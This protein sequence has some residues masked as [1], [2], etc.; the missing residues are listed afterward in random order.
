M[1]RFKHP[2]CCRGRAS[3]PKLLLHAIVSCL[4]CTTLNAGARAQDCLEWQYPGAD[5]WGRNGHAMTY[6]STHG[7]TVLFGGRYYE[8]DGLDGN[9]YSGETWTWDGRRWTL[10]SISGPPR[11]AAGSMAHDPIRGR[12]ILFGGGERPPEGGS[13]VY[14]GDTWA[15]D[16]R[17]WHNLKVDGPFA[18]AGH[19]MAYDAARGVVVLFGGSYFLPDHGYVYDPDT[20]KWDG[21]SW[22][23]VPA[24]GP[25]VRSFASVAYDPAR[26][27]TVL[28]GGYYLNGQDYFSHG[29]TWEW[30][31]SS[32][33][34]VDVEGPSSRYGAGMAYDPSRHGVILYG[35]RTDT[36]EDAGTWL[37]DGH[38]WSVIA[39]GPDQRSLAGFAL[40]QGRE[41]VVMFGGSYSDYEKSEE[42]GFSSETFE[43]DG[44][45]WSFRQWTGAKHRS[46]AAMVFDEARRTLV[47]FGG[48]DGALDGWTW[49]RD[50]DAWVR[51]ATNG[52]SPRTR[53]AMAYDR[54]RG[55]TVLFGG[56]DGRPDDETW[57]WDGMAWI[58]REAPGPS[59]RYGHTMAYDPV[60]REI[61]LFG[62]ERVQ[63]CLATCGAGT[64]PTGD[65]SQSAALH[66]AATPP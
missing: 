43:W 34:Q 23:N 38:Q 8:Y 30:D 13:T 6:D 25:S 46:H 14:F 61:L 60:R 27:V 29:D 51:R 11:R 45:G 22:L 31:G 9:E 21:S 16:G 52:P 48:Y 62:G 15:W 4:G 47:M 59:P 37:F 54:A 40:D 32:W 10:K 35:G 39:E 44:T 5:L 3:R 57:L 49:E 53:H 2:I 24:E 56:T 65:C 50:A 58:R 7:Q 36:G 63:A 28:F 19:A 33:S 42:F 66:R 55:I 41:R 18:R 12:T 17:R 26:E 20:W 1:N 64:E